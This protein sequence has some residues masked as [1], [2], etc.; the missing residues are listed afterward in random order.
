MHTMMKESPTLPERF[1]TQAQLDEF[2]SRPT[3]QTAGFIRALEGD[4]MILGAGGKM[5][6]GLARLLRRA[7]QLNGSQKRII[8]VSRFSSPEVRQQIEAAGVE[9]I[10]CDLMKEDE[11]E[12]LPQAANILY[13][14][15][16]K[17]GTTGQEARTWAVNAYLPGRIASRFPRARF[18]VLSSG[19]I[20]PL[21]PLDSGGCQEDAPP[22]PV[23]EYAQSVLGRERIFG[24]FAQQ[25]D[26]PSVFIRLNYAV[27]LRYGVLLD[28]AQR[29]WSGQAVDL[30]MGYF[31]AI[32]QG[33]AYTCI[34]GAL[35]GAERPGMILNVTGP[36]TISVRW[37]AGEFGRRMEVQPVF[38]GQEAGSALLNNA[39]LAHQLFGYPRVSLGQCIEWV[40]AWVMAGNPTFE[41]PTH[42]EARDGK[43]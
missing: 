1:E 39:A 31:N 38:S 29:V 42:Y 8:A 24:H 32:W 25:N 30:S 26:T 33:D 4:V 6:P 20:Y 11:L 2:L 43:F 15:A 22:G 23:G 40:T 17:F 9:T 14:P 19:N 5:G 41:K 27:E 35:A 12:A 21:V 28:V 37:L 13:L 3:Q 10:A 7:V 36:E 34:L 16:V 18:A